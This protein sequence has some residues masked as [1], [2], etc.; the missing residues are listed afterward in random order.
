MSSFVLL[1]VA[2]PAEVEVTAEHDAVWIDATSVQQTLGWQLKPEGLCRGDTCIPV[3][4]RSGL[5][6]YGAM[7]LK[8][9]AD[10]LG[11]PLALSVE[12]DA[13]YLGPPAS[14]YGQTVGSLG[15]PDFSLPDLDG[16][17]HSLSEH[18]GSKVL[19]AAWASW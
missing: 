2:R 18:R 16:H 8:A 9:L 5:V 17:P 10:L 12:E 3:S 14:L 13:A 15:A 19:L 6:R 11:R 1:D 7:H 4:D